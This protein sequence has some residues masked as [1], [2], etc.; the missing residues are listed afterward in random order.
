MGSYYDIDA[1]LTD[2]E[3]VPCTFNL[4]LPGLGYLDENPGEDIQA[5]HSTPLP[6]WLATLLAVQRLP[7]GTPICQ[8][9]LPTSIGGVKEVNALK[10]NPKVVDLRELSAHYY[11]LAA[12]VLELW[13]EEELVAVLCEVSE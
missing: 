8:L 3:K 4:D 13:D 11:E 9:D 5:N 2:A 12:R 1:I 10:A 6:L 7:S